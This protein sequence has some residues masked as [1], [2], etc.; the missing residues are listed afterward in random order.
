MTK[1]ISPSN[2]SSCRFASNTTDIF[3]DPPPYTRHA[4]NF[5][6]VLDMDHVGK[7]QKTIHRPLWLLLFFTL[8]SGSLAIAYLILSHRKSHPVAPSTHS[9]SLSPTSTTTNSHAYPLQVSFVDL[10]YFRGERALWMCRPRDPSTEIWPSR[11][12]TLETPRNLSLSSI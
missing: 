2:E 5:P 1:C 6:P 7:R 8:M 4:P 9:A 11:F 10:D 12:F 3:G